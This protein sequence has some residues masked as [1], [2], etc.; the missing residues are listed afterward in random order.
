MLKKEVLDAQVT[1]ELPAREMMQN[2]AFLLIGQQNN[3]AQLGLINVQGVQINA[4]V[5]TVAQIDATAP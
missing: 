4:A 3:S 1:L 5:V 2:L